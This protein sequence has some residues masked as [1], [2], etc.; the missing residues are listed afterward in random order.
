MISR[1][2]K[3]MVE[4]VFNQFCEKYSLSQEQTRLIVKESRR[5]DALAGTVISIVGDDLGVLMF[6]V[7][8]DNLVLDLAYLKEP[9]PRKGMLTTIVELFQSNRDVLGVSGFG[10]AGVTSSPMYNWC[11]K[12]NLKHLDGPRRWTIVSKTPVDYYIRWD[13]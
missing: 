10:V 9:Y 3:Q 4:Q 6:R 1:D 13:K 7:V 2:A 12:N 11:I 5:K 8:D